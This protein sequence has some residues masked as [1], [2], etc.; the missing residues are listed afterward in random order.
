MNPGTLYYNNDVTDLYTKLWIGL[1]HYWCEHQ[2][3]PQICY[4][5]PCDA[6]L[7]EN[8]D[9]LGKTLS[10]QII[11]TPAVR[12]SNFFFTIGDPIASTVDPSS[13]PQ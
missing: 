2:G 9:R 12:P 8:I 1:N 6:D 3:F 5:N 10:L 4:V 11:S 7:E 13:E